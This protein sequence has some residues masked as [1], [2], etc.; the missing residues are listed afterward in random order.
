[1]SAFKSGRS[2]TKGWPLGVWAVEYRVAA[3]PFLLWG[4]EEEE[5]EEVEEKILNVEFGV[6]EGGLPGVSEM[7]DGV[8]LLALEFGFPGGRGW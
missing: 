5:E 1:M 2:L 8:F 3:S 6:E 4:E 7:W